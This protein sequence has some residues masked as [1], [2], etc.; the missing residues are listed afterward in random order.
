VVISPGDWIYRQLSET[1]SALFEGAAH[2]PSTVS[3]LLL[4]ALF[5]TIFRDK[6]SHSLSPADF[7]FLL[8][9]WMPAS[10]LFSSVRL[11]QLVA[12]AALVYLQFI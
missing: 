4:Q 9:L 1:L 2:L 6:T 12:I 8:F 5:I 3:P 7:I 11:Y 10:F